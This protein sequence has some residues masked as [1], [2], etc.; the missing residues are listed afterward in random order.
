MLGNFARYDSGQGH[1]RVLQALISG[2]TQEDCL[3]VFRNTIKTAAT[4]FR[5]VKL[6]HCLHSD[7]A[8]L[9]SG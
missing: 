5:I 7:S 8:T 1:A 4:C 2:H 6:S 9:K 3:E